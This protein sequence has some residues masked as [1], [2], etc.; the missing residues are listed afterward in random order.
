MALQLITEFNIYSLVSEIL[1]FVFIFPDV[2]VI[3]FVFSI[4]SFMIFF[5]TFRL[6]PTSQVSKALGFLNFLVR[7]KGFHCPQLS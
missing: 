2:F 1:V 6:S 4:L 3:V 5:Q 7:G